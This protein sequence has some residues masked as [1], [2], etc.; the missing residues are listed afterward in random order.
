VVKATSHAQSFSFLDTEL[1]TAGQGPSPG[2][3]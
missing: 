3:I 1:S 2:A